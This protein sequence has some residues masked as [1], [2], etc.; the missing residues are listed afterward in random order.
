MYSIYPQGVTARE[1]SASGG[2]QFKRGLTKIAIVFGGFQQIK[3]NSN[4]YYSTLP[5]FENFLFYN[6]IK[7]IEIV[8]NEWSIRLGRKGMGWELMLTAAISCGGPDP[9]EIVS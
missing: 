8:L 3:L 9:M 7:A 5:P 1:T 2:W 4:L 6:Q